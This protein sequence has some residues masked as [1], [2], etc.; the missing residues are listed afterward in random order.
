MKS[1]GDALGKVIAKSREKLGISQEKLAERAGVHRTYVSQL[2][3]GLKS[4]TLDILSKI[5]L[6][7]D[8]KLSRLMRLL[9]DELG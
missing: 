6:G 1:T 8:I 5:S 9:E 7:L 3:R 4:P 2:E